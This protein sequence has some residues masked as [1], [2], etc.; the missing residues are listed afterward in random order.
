MTNNNSILDDVL[1]GETKVDFPSADEITNRFIDEQIAAAKQNEDGNGALLETL[2][3]IIK[4]LCS[5]YPSGTSFG[6]EEYLK[7]AMNFEVEIPY[8]ILKEFFDNWT[9]ALIKAKR[10]RKYEGCYFQSV[11]SIQ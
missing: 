10:C 9:D 2:I 6:I 11:Y 1:T 3:R 8:P 4:T 5:Y 7:I